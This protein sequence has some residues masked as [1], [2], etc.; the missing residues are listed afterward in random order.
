MRF[1]TPVVH[2]NV[3][4][5]TGDICLDLLKDKWTPMYTVLNCVRAVRMRRAYPDT[6]C[7]VNLDVAVLLREG[8][9]LG[10]KSLVEC[11]IRLEG[12]RY[13]GP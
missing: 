12:G 13:L 10:A 9:V 2:A 3:A 7:P 1:A 5:G 6:N 8:D 11:Y 4:L